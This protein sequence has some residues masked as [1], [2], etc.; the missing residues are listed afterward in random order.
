MAE[1]F[2]Y[3]WLGLVYC[4]YKYNVSTRHEIV[5]NCFFWPLFV[6]KDFIELVDRVRRRE[7]E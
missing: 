2:I 6:L 1:L 4:V 7:D 3:F 5:L